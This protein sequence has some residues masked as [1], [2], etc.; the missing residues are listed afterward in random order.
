MDQD[1]DLRLGFEDLITERC[2]STWSPGGPT[3]EEWDLV[4]PRVGQGCG[5]RPSRLVDLKLRI[6][7]PHI[8]IIQG[9]T[10]TVVAKLVNRDIAPVA[11]DSVVFEGKL[12]G[13]GGGWNTLHTTSSLVLPARQASEVGMPF[14]YPLGDRHWCFRVHVYFDDAAAQAASGASPAADD[15]APLGTVLATNKT[16]IA[17]SYAVESDVVGRHAVLRGTGGEELYSLPFDGLGGGDFEHVRILGYEADELVEM[18]AFDRAQFMERL[19]EPDAQEAAYLWQNG[20]LT[21]G[22]SAVEDTLLNQAAI[23]YAQTL[24]L[25]APVTGESTKESI[26]CR[27]NGCGPDPLRGTIEG[28]IN[29]GGRWFGGQL[30]FCCNDHDCCYHGTSDVGGTATGCGEL[31]RAICD[32]LFLDCMALVCDVSEY[33]TENIA[34]CKERAMAMFVIVREFMGRSSGNYFNWEGCDRPPAHM[35][36]SRQINTQSVARGSKSQSWWIPYEAA[37]AETLRVHSKAILPAGWTYSLAG[38]EGQEV[39]GSGSLRVDVQAADGDTTGTGRVILVALSTTGEYVAEAEIAIVDPDAPAVP[40]S[41]CSGVRIESIFPQ[42][43]L[44]SAEI[45]LS[46][47][48]AGNVETK[49]VDLRGRVVRVLLQG[50]RAAGTESLVWDGADDAGRRVASGLYFA[51]AAGSCGTRDVQRITMLR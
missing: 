3:A 26:P 9:D 14:T 19:R 6:S 51:V 24:Y 44:R 8:R 30:N 12:F 2:P 20:P 1:G 18:S 21:A 25:L 34:R 16:G 47:G 45:K 4:V 49:I 29:A 35:R 23:T 15:T 42:P 43:C 5:L 7:K 13:L 11:V 41:E 40:P 10:I 37:P 50:W 27:R 31:D 46:V 38:G 48:Q 36:K 32:V 39:T 33:G 22:S 17:V 28:W